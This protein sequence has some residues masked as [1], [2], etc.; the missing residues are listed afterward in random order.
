[1]GHTGL[2]D[3]RGSDSTALWSLMLWGVRQHLSGRVSGTDFEARLRA[4]LGVSPKA[5]LA[6]SRSA[7]SLW[8]WLISR[9]GCNT[10]WY[11]WYQTSHRP[12]IWDLQ[13]NEVPTAHIRAARHERLWFRLCQPLQVTKSVPGDQFPRFG[14][15]KSFCP[16]THG[17]W[18]PSIRWP[19]VR[20][21]RPRQHVPSTAYQFG[22]F[23]ETVI[24]QAF[25]HSLPRCRVREPRR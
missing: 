2:F 9:D 18:L 24:W 12:S 8:A 25:A 1:M 21:L 4:S 17:F 20:F 16:G 5:L 13:S 23:N 19:Q 6:L 11:W 10:S 22:I 15:H 3:T 7:L 14:E